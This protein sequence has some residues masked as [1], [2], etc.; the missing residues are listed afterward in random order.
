MRQTF[1]DAQIADFLR[2]SYFAADGLWFVKTEERHGFDEAMELDEAVWEIMPRIQARKARALLGIEGGG[3]AELARAF[4]LKLS[5]EGYKFD[6][7]IDADRV[8]FTVLVCPWFEI[9]KSSRRTHVAETVAE[10][11]CAREYAGWAREFGPGID[12]ET[13]GRLCVE[14]DRC[15][16]CTMVFSKV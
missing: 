13:R 12:F 14:S 10:R 8:V 2:K 6:V 15:A 5:A 16:R 11:I 9:L 1:P 4:Q 3:L 7:V